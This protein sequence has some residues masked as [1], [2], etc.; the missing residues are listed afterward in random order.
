MLHKVKNQSFVSKASGCVYFWSEHGI[1]QTMD[2]LEPARRSTT[3]MTRKEGHVSYP[4]I[5]I[6]HSGDIQTKTLLTALMYGR[7]SSVPT[8]GS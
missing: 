1:S 3:C 2:G 4:S 6:R 5:R 7:L 8:K